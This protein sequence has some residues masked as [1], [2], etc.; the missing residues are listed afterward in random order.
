[1]LVW[2]KKNWSIVV[3]VLVTISF[4]FY[5][6]SCEPKVASLFDATRKVNRQEF[7]LEL[8]Q[9]MGLAQIRMLDFERYDQFRA[10]VLQNA[11][12]LI[13][14]QPLNPVG[15]ITAI[16]GIY[17]FTQAGSKVTKVVKEKR[18]KRKEN[19]GHA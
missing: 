3:G 7:Q 14:G 6:Y 16:A 4:L 9:L 10:I 19:N 2:L 12:L 15:I 8:D 17:G 18:I 11:I 1:M 5:A 13:Q